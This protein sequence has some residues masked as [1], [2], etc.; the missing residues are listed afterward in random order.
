MCGIVGYV[1]PRQAVEF[2]LAG[3]R[4]LEY[5]G[6]DS[7]G[8]ATIGPDGQ[9]AIC[10]T[11]GRVETL[12]ERLAEFPTP[13]HDRYRPH[14]LGHPRGPDRRKLAPAHGR[15]SRVG[16][17]PQRRDRKLPPAQGAPGSRRLRF[18]LRYGQRNH[19]PPTGKLLA[20]GPR[21][22]RRNQRRN[23][24]P[25]NVKPA[26]DSNV[27][28]RNGRRCS[29]CRPD[30]DRLWVLARPG[31]RSRRHGPGAASRH[32]WPGDP[33]PRISR[34]DHRRP[35]GQPAGGRR[36]R[37]RALRRQR[38]LAAGRLHRQDR[39]SGRPSDRRGHRRFAAK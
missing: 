32:L 1:G 30:R 16:H 28:M 8:I 36:G 14:A 10:K 6:Y 18:S 13:W 22:I 15:A 4:R 31:D 2:L 37:R 35:A 39:L 20:A 29:H 38:R 34:R 19:R 5:R 9:F 11:A 27:H 12:E 26:R 25:R 24:W 7:S 3:L 33:V 23:K 21:V 17:R